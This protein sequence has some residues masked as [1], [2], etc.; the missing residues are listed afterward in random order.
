M[1]EAHVEKFM[2]LYSA[3]VSAREQMVFQLLPVPGS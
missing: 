3:S 2:V 1:W